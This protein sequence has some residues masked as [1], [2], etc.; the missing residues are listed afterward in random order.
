MISGMLVN[1][2]LILTLVCKEKLM[3]L[4]F[5]KYQHVV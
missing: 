4:A 3:Y 2:S 5:W 1:S